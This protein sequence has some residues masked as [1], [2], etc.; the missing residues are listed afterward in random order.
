[1]QRPVLSQKAFS[2]FSEEE[3]KI[4]NRINNEHL[5]EDV[6]AMRERAEADVKAVRQRIDMQT[7]LK[8]MDGNESAPL[9][10]RRNQ[11]TK[12]TVH[13]IPHTHDDVGWVKTR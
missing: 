4:L 2:E 5:K 13:I 10:P 6:N 1:M 7:S 3:K 12:L 9:R 11:E 8:K